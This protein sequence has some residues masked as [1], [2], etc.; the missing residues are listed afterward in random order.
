MARQKI[1]FTEKLL[2]RMSKDPE[3]Q[4]K[5]F[6][7]AGCRGLVVH[8]AVNGEVTFKFRARV[9]GGPKARVHE[10]LDSWSSAYKLEDAQDA[11]RARRSDIKK[12]GLRPP[13]E[14]VTVFESI[15]KYEAARRRK[16]PLASR[17][18]APLGKK[19]PE[20][21]KRF[22]VVFKDLL[23]TDVNK[24][25]RVDFTGCMERYGD[26]C[27]KEDRKQHFQTPEKDRK[28]AKDG[29]E[30]WM[31]DP[32]RLRPMMVYANPM[33]EW[34][35][36]QYRLD[37]REVYGLVP[38]DYGK[39]DRYLLPGE[40]QASAPHIDALECE[41]GLFWRFLLLTAT[42][43]T[44]ASGMQ[45][46]ELNWGEWRYWTDEDGV[47]HKALIWIP[48]RDRMKGRDMDGGEDLAR[49]VLIT[50]ETLTVLEKLRA[51]WERNHAMPEHAH[52]NGVFTERMVQR[53]YSARTDLQRGVEEKAGTKPWD[54]MSLR[55]THATYLGF[56]G[57]PPYL[58]T[59]SMNHAV[60]A[61]VEAGK[62]FG[63]EAAAVTG[64]YDTSD[65][66]HDLRPNDPFTQLAPWHRRFQ[67]LLK[68][69]ERGIKSDDLTA[70]QVDMRDGQRCRDMCKNN[71]INRAL[72]DVKPPR[73]TVVA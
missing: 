3:H 70:M 26:E 5:T 17:R 60:K 48:P 32:R 38:P 51:I 43:T 58:V 46:D 21:I 2:G 9:K 55:H 20:H 45:W 37:P 33:L 1:I 52:W 57:C 56:L 35:T 44:Q 41:L 25:K 18:R 28:P 67:R 39:D 4:G 49:R 71:E 50:G 24:L 16:D 69:I 12:N 7:D 54:R 40:W 23:G 34:Y 22:Q 27:E 8:I 65:K 73:L 61:D 13:A 66:S 15:P 19:W 6:S 59:L 68:D 53:F 62:K 36:R 64:R 72:I 47:R 14:S 42:R 30:P 63:I 11:V 10:G 31:W 29:V